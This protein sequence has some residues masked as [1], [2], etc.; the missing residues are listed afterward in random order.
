VIKILS[1]LR[2]EGCRFSAQI[3]ITAGAWSGRGQDV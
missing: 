3:W 2:T 1:L